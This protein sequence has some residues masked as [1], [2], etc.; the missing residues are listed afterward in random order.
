MQ[1]DPHCSSSSHGWKINSRM[2]PFLWVRHHTQ[3]YVRRSIT[4]IK[5]HLALF[6]MFVKK[7]N[8]MWSI[9]CYVFTQSQ[10]GSHME[11][12]ARTFRYHVQVH[13]LPYMSSKNNLKSISRNCGS[14]VICAAKIR[15]FASPFLFWSSD[16]FWSKHQVPSDS[17][18]QL[19]ALLR[20]TNHIERAWS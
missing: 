14:S 11:V 12:C 6:F 1:K 16:F 10:P 18:A 3:V 2:N 8:I 4:E 17:K 5:W 9:L 20:S 15:R 13:K 7:H 19:K